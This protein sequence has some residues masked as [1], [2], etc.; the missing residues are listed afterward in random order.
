VGKF[1]VAA[2]CN[3]TASRNATLIV[4]SFTATPH[5]ILAEYE[6]QTGCKWEK[7]YTTLDR[8]KQIE[9]EEY[10]VYSALATVVTLRRIWT[11]G[12]TLFK[13]Y[14]ETLLGQVD[15]ETL[16]SQVTA[17]I[18]KQEEGEGHFPSLMRKLTLN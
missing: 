13:Y 18:K 2:L 7:S 9:T 12:G 5:E 15:T 17:N 8:L 16:E 11:D 1:V 14:D 4:H 6:R 10:R 3:T